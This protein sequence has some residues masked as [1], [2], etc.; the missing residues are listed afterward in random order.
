MDLHSKPNRIEK[1]HGFVGHLGP[2]KA[3]PN[4]CFLVKKTR[5]PAGYSRPG[6][7][8]L[9][10][11]CAVCLASFTGAPGGPEGPGEG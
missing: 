10:T 8:S 7:E 11:V 5:V 3:L 9:V 4:P 2:E 1:T 6:F